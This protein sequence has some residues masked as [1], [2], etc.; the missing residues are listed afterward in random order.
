MTDLFVDPEGATPLSDA[1]R[2]GL[3]RADIAL[4]GVD[5]GPLLRFARS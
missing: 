4:R 5:Y 3:L 2:E 1:D